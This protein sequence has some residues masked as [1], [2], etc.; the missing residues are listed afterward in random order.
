MIRLGLR[1]TLGGGKQAA[2]RLVITALAVALGVGMLLIA[3]AGINAVNAQNARYGWLETGAGDTAPSDSG[4]GSDPLWWLLTPDEF[5]GKI[6]GRVDVA[7]TGP[8]SPI[9]PGIPALPEPGQYYASP[10]LSTLLRSTPAAQLGDRYPGTQIGTIGPAAL[11][12]PNS[13]IIVIGRTADQLAHMPGA[14]HVTRISTTPPS[15]CNGACYYLGINASGID[16]ILSV[17]AAALLFPILI[18]IG[19]ATRLS[20]ARREQR[21]AAMRLVGAT[22]RQVS[23]ISAVESTVAATAGVGIGFGLFFLIRP[24]LAPIPFTGAPF[25]LHDLSLS[26]ADVLL[27]TLG[28]PAAAAV[29][30]RLALRRVTISPL[31]VTRRVTPRP[32]RAWRVILVLAGTGELAYFVHAG[33]PK[34]TPGQIAAYL[35]GI[36]VI[37]AG[38]VIAGPWLTMIGSRI[39]ARRA[40]RP[41][42]L[43]AGRRLAD[44]PQAGFRAIS[45]LILALFVGSVSVGIIT[46]IEVYAGGTGVDAAARA[47]LVDQVSNFAPSGPPLLS[48]PPLP[49]HLVS[50]LR[51]I[52][53]VQ[54]V[55]LVHTDP[56]GNDDLGPALGLVSCAQL[57]HTPALGRCQAGAAVATSQQRFDRRRNP[58]DGPVWPAAPLSE[59]RLRSLPIRSIAVATNGSTAAIEQARTILELAY[60]QLRFPPT[61]IA[62][63]IAQSP[64]NQLNSQYRQLANVVILASLI[65]A[66]CSLAVSV[67][68]GLNDRKR[69]FSLLRLTGAPLATLRRVVALES[70]VPLLITALTSIGMGFLAA[71]LFLRSQLDETLQPPGAQYYAVIL[72]GLACSLAV[73]ASTLP[74]LNRITGPETAR[75]E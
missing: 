72:A 17:A 24:A 63:D 31:G 26:L 61:T 16:L 35:P 6:I 55:T 28:V 49:D 51:S 74:L 37:M 13:L 41:A 65:V 29:A 54:A 53:G 18:F 69:P 62:E 7:A 22:P 9:P 23:V 8:R 27:I 40:N 33:R 36:L 68:A 42:T 60:P 11:P 67:A 66:G 47:T 57:V 30:A 46:T 71:Y 48:V 73:I 21:F 4:S 45:G 50:Q 75:N 59:E 2:V 14:T 56:M 3:L 32:P 1:L 34:S 15:S 19:T 38:L 70:A 52:P 39:L 44:N 58:R 20:A 12:A 25:F 64:N 5:Q 43:I 10:A